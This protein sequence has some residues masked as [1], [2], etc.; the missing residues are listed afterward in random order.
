MTLSKSIWVDLEMDTGI[1]VREWS[2]DFRI[3]IE[4]A[5]VSEADTRII[6]F[7]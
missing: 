4:P 3:T 6:H 1:G 7:S 5:E 2:E